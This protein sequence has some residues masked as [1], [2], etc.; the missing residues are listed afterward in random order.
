MTASSVELLAIG[1]GWLG[2]RDRVK[3]YTASV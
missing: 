3:P 2:G 1:R